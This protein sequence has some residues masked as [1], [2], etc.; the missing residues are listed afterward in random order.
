MRQRES[1]EFAQILNRLREGD[2]TP[3]DIVKLKE[4]C[5]SE[6]CRNYPIDV[7]HLFIQNSKVD[8][9]NNRVHMATTGD[10]YAIKA[11]DNVVGANSAELRDKIL[12][13]IPLDPRKTMQLAFNLQL[14]E[15]ERTEIT[16]GDN[17][18][19]RCF[20]TKPKLFRESGDFSGNRDTWKFFRETR[21]NSGT[22]QKKIGT[23]GNVSPKFGRMIQ[24]SGTT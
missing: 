20:G 6:N 9:F 4:R 7:P 19:K 3:D 10:K 1:K 8:E 11:L 24:I 2:H 17:S 14:A 5:I 16:G 23:S 18:T 12:K 13:Q 15:G 22:L 21:D